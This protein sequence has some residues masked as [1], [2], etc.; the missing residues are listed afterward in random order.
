MTKRKKER[1]GLHIAARRHL[2]VPFKHR[3]RDPQKGIDCV[4]LAVLAAIECGWT[5]QDLPVYGR[6]PKD[7]QL[8]AQLAAN[9]TRICTNPTLDQLQ[10]G[11]LVAIRFSPRDAVRHVGIVGDH[12]HGLSL[13]HTDSHI[14]RVV[15]QRIDETIL[16]RIAAVYRRAA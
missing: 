5:V 6:L 11:D 8:E 7:G 3:G 16:A 12:P 2:G 15:E 1:T 9:A 14:G 10:P 4:G 13:I